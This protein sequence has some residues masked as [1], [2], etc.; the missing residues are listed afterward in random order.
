MILRSDSS[1]SLSDVWYI[2]D[3][4]YQDGSVMLRLFSEGAGNVLE[5]RNRFLPYV[6]LQGA[7]PVDMEYVRSLGGAAEIES[8]KKSSLFEEEDAN[9]VRVR[10]RSRD[11]LDALTKRF[12]VWESDV[13]PELSYMYDN[14]LSFCVPYQ[15]RGDLLQ[16]VD[17]T[18]LKARESFL[19]R[20]SHLEQTDPLKYQ[21]IRHFFFICS[22]P[23]PAINLQKIGLQDASA[24]DYIR[25]TTLSRIACIPLR[26]SL[27]SGRVSDWIRSILNS[28]L[29]RNNILIPTP[30]ELLRGDTRSSVQGALT[31]SPQSG[32]Y[33]NMVVVDFESL[34]PSCIDRFNLSYE[35]VNCSHQQCTKNLVPGIESQYVCA[36]RR[37]FYSALIGALRDLRV[38]WFKPISREGE[39][40]EERQLARAVSGILKLILVSS[41]GVTVRTKGLA[42]PTLAES[43]TAYGRFALRSSWDMAERKGL[44]PRYGDTDSLFLENPSFDEVH[45]LI[46]SVRQGIGLD[47]AVDKVYSVCVLTRA[48]KAYF[49]VTGDGKIDAKGLAILKSSSPPLFQEVFRRCASNLRDVNSAQ[50]FERAK[51]KIVGCIEEAVRR[52]RSGEVNLEDLQHS[53]LIHIDPA[54]KV[55][56]EVLPQAYQ[57]IAQLIE[58]GRGVERREEV[59]FVKV[60]PF[61]HAG[62]VFTVKPLELVRDWSEINIEDYVRSL[63]S[64]LGQVLEPM[65]IDLERQRTGKLSDWM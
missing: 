53:V 17:A 57:S 48:M 20:F 64:N 29:R 44:R 25:A 62:R 24:E 55:E 5:L 14:H 34:Y 40:N 21:L 60:K 8:V 41:Y 32:T 65:R 12:R 1:S 31:I 43:I 58:A 45:R 23:F 39:T 28:S 19:E 46:D 33:F 18:P 52:I 13:S 54:E 11:V 9:L 61:K 3:V 22:Q 56:A 27:I 51:G 63:K 30:E 26:K 59:K 16:P 37:G 38:R 42:S 4:E 47:L 15:R 7:S 36:L 2:Y 6:Y 10:V 49:G 35:T 50:D